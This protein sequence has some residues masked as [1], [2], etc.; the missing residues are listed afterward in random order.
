MNED[1]VQPEL[2]QRYFF[3]MCK[4]ITVHTMYGKGCMFAENEIYCI[5]CAIVHRRVFNVN[6]NRIIFTYERATLMNLLPSDI[7]IKHD[8]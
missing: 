7:I 6:K 5:H 3:S 1:L 8:D 2:L 4:Q